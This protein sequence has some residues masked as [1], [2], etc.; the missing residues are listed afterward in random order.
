MHYTSL[1]DSVSFYSLLPEQRLLNRNSLPRMLFERLR[2]LD[3][4]SPD[5]NDSSQRELMQVQHRLE[6]SMIK[7]AHLQQVRSTFE[8][9]NVLVKTVLVRGCLT[10]A[11]VNGTYAK[12]AACLATS[13]AAGQVG[14]FDGPPHVQKDANN[15]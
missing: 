12:M 5:L 15:T 13:V 2:G 4:P 8:G 6:E 9:R 11:H 1:L 3:S 10:S 14:F 7:N